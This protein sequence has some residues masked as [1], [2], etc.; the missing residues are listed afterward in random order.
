[1]AIIGG[2]GAG[3]STLARRLG[4]VLGVRVHHIDQMYWQDNWQLR[5][6]REFSALAM[7]ALEQENWV[8][9]GYPAQFRKTHGDQLDALIFLDT[10]YFVRL[11]RVLSRSVKN[12]KKRGSDNAG[13]LAGV[14]RRE[15]I[16]HWLFGWHLKAHWRCKAILDRAP[17]NV[18]RVHLRN[19]KEVAQFLASLK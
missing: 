4:A 7:A 13:N 12:G 16:Y 2:S 5:D 14:F 19:S 18:K 9:D 3:K 11:W 6:E 10:P 15:F 17:D 1:M 8:F